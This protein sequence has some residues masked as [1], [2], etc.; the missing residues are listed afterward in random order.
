M[1]VDREALALAY[2]LH[3]PAVVRFLAVFAG[4]SVD[5]E[6]LAQ[7]AFV[8]LGRPGA[9]VPA[10]RVRFWLI[11]V[12]RNLALNELRRRRPAASL[13]AAGE[14]R[15]PAND[16]ETALLSRDALKTC[17]AALQSLPEQWRSMLLLRELEEMSYAE[18]AAMLGV[19]AAK[20]KS[21]LFR[22]RMRMRELLGRKS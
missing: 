6:D 16:P 22:A 5:A 1:S 13:D 9:D 7:E 3:Y 19:S 21:D 17:A 11:R 4:G 12:A 8:R 15:D 14:V 10:D 2:R 20:V 18:I